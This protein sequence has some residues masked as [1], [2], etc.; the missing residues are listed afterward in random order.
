M[1]K[2]SIEKALWILFSA[3]EWKQNESFWVCIVWILL[4]LCNTLET[5]LPDSVGQLTLL[6]GPPQAKLPAGR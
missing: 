2:W 4:T 5:K 3:K 1:Q 6:Q